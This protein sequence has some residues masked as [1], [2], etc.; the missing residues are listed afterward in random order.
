MFNNLFRHENIFLV[1]NNVNANVN[2]FNGEHKNRYLTSN[3][4]LFL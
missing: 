3:E 2:R 1:I 4:K